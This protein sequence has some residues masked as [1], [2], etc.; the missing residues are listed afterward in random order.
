MLA[1]PLL[2]LY[3][4]HC[5]DIDGIR[6]A[7]HKQPFEPFAIRMADGRGLPVPHPDFVAVVPRRIVVVAEDG[8]WSVVDPRLVASLDYDG[9]RS[10][11]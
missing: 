11:R 1:C 7:L 6:E 3:G 4:V 8:S 5:M 2:I 10:A 9:T